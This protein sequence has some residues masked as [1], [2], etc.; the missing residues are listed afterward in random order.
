MNSY[1]PRSAQCQF[2]L[3]VIPQR[4]S[5]WENLLSTQQRQKFDDLTKPT[6]PQ[7]PK[8]CDDSFQIL[9]GQGEGWGVKVGIGGGEE[10]RRRSDGVMMGRARK[11]GAARAVGRQVQQVGQVR[12]TTKRRLDPP[13]SEY[14]GSQGHQSPCFCLSF[15]FF[16]AS[17]TLPRS[18]FFPLYY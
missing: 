17:G 9:L 6:D 12:L 4:S 13:L 8:L 15:F 2:S 1:S 10:R 5:L 18:L 3:G 14:N 16:L 7:Q 11:R